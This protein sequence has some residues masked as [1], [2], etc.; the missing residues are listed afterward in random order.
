MGLK[1]IKPLMQMH[2]IQLLTF[3]MNLKLNF[4]TIGRSTSITGNTSPMVAAAVA[5]AN[6]GAFPLQL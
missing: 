2:R 3:S 1:N 6:S 5:I 4:K